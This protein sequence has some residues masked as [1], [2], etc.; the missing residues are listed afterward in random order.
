MIRCRNC[1]GKAAQ[2]IGLC[3]ECLRDVSDSEKLADLHS[4]ARERY[5]LPLRPP[6]SR[7][8]TV[9]TICANSCRIEPGGCGYCGINRNESGQ[10]ASIV[11]QGALAHMYLDP[12][13]TNCCAAWFCSGSHERGYNL[14]VFFYGCNFDCLFCQNASHK[15]LRDARTVSLEEMVNAALDPRVR[16][17]CFFGGSPEPQLPFA[18]RAAREIIKESDNRKHICWEWNGCGNP[19]LVREAAELSS[20]SGGTAKFDLKCSH[21]NMSL[22]L[23]GVSNKRSFENFR[24]I[25]E[26]GYGDI[27]TA[28]TLLVPYYVDAEEVRAIASFIATIDSNIPYSMLVFHPDFYLRDLPIT[29]RGQVDECYGVARSYL[30]R[31]NIGNEHLLRFAE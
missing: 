11:S 8:G 17:V 25:S 7:G 15:L 14:A 20:A 22:A 21:P 30:Q 26:A 31:V 16:C 2:A 29:P 18:L 3:A 6:R 4:D 10:I 24:M 28:T 12:L 13:P 27:L 23:C 9:C 19:A 1:G 5:G